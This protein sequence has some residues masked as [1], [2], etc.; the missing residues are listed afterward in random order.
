MGRYGRGIYAVGVIGGGVT[1]AERQVIAE[2]AILLACFTLHLWFIQAALSF[3]IA[4]A[5]T[6]TLSATVCG[7]LALFP[8]SVLQKLLQK[9]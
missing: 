6:R 7:A 1:E 4:G 3:W 5:N 8:K 2:F 9:I